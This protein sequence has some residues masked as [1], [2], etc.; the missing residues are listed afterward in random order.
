MTKA[1][2][3]ESVAEKIDVPRATAEGAVNTVFA[4]IVAA[5]KQGDK[6]TIAGFGSFV[7]ANRN[8]RR[9]RNPRTLA[10]VEIPASKAARFNPSKTLKHALKK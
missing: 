6:V 3:I 10:P 7:V 2:L 9:G 4:D 1:E 5:L 8:A